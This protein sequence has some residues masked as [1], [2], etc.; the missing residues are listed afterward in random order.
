MIKTKTAI[1]QKKIK[2]RI[3]IKSEDSIRRFAPVVSRAPVRQRLAEIA[4]YCRA[5]CDPR[6]RSAGP[7]PALGLCSSMSS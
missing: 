7:R 6:L 2:T 4:L 5:L 3:L 1:D